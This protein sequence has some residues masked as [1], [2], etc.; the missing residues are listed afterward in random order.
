MERSSLTRRAILAGVAASTA[1]SQS[2]PVP[3]EAQ[4]NVGP[5]RRVAS[6]GKMIPAVGLGTWITFNVGRDPKL[7]DR[8][9][10]VMR[11]FFDA[12][13]RVIDS[14]PMYGSSQDTLGYGF[15]KLGRPEGLFAADKVWTSSS[16]EGPRQIEQS[17]TEWNV[18]RFSLVQVHNL[19]AWQAHLPMLLNKK[20]NG[21]IDHVGITTS[22]GRRHQELLQIM[23]EQPLDFVQI[24]YNV[25]DRE[26]EDEI[27]PLAQ[28]RGIA[29]M[30]NR[31]FRR[32]AL[33]RWLEGRPLPS[34]AAEIGT[35]TWA[36]F[37][38]KFILSHPAV[39]VAIPATTR[40][41]HA[42]ENV[43]AASGAMPGPDMR[44]RMAKHVRSL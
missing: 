8:S 6:T 44:E 28:E 14:S 43:A 21:E 4:E 34:F 10:D 5:M 18:P 25:L 35:A 42:Q 12:G 27:L 13:G 7:L 20:A 32:G 2:V 41:D 1:L 29:V 40:P 3:V 17:R 39:T 15:E 19:R 16:E 9:A 33:T 36:Q 23:R 31:P 38:L 37:L 11:A 22:H 26:V 24:T 30:V